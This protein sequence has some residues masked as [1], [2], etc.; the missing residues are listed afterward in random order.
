MD[1]ERVV[2]CSE[3]S[4]MAWEARGGGVRECEKGAIET[5]FGVFPD[6]NLAG[7]KKKG[8]SF[9]LIFDK[10]KIQTSSLLQNI[11]LLSSI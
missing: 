10:L 1:V 3:G 7:E 11:K 6:K 5:L 4:S 9:S 2:R 8:N